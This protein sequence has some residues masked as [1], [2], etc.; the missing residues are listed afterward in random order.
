MR[1]LLWKS[2]RIIG[3]ASIVMFLLGQMARRTPIGHLRQL[4]CGPAGAHRERLQAVRPVL[5][6]HGFAMYASAFFTALNNGPVSALIVSRTLVF[7]VAAVI[8]LP[9]LFGIDG[10]WLGHGG[11]R[12]HVPD[13]RHVHDRPVG[14]LRLPQRRLSPKAKRK[15]KTGTR[16][17]FLH[18]SQLIC[19][20]SA[21]LD[22]E[23]RFTRAGGG[24]SAPS[25][26]LLDV[27]APPTRRRRAG[28]LPRCRR[29]SGACRRPPT[30]P[31]R[32]RS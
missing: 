23:T 26:A 9:M 21:P 22:A 10:I 27:A 7:Q 17:R 5:S 30:R 14:P 31:Q 1:S 6:V 15:Q 4:R 28:P 12:A 32:P 8:V 20:I 24:R 25:P 18:R 2:L 16:P 29:G 11:R 13:S 3:V 19:I